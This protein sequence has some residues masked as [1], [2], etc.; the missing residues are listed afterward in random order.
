M[1]ALAGKLPG[2]FPRKLAGQ[3]GVL[4]GFVLGALVLLVVASAVLSDFRLSLLGRFVCFAIVAVGI[5]WRG[6]AA[7][8]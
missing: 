2:R 8:C 7:A 3:R 6:A 1:T 5:A 4:L